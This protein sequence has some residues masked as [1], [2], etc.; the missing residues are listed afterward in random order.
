MLEI[1]ARLG[2]KEDFSTEWARIFGSARGIK[3]CGDAV[4][5]YR[6]FAWKSN[7]ALNDPSLRAEG[8][9]YCEADD[10]AFTAVGLYAVLDSKQLVE[11]RLC[12]CLVLYIGCW[13]FGSEFSN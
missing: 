3:P 4:G 7:L 12:H 8:P 13:V 6:V 2:G 1:R 9:A 11:E 5:A 10:A